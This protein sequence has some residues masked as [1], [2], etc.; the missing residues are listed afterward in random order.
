MAF[1]KLKKTLLIIYHDGR[2]GQNC[3]E[4]TLS[5]LGPKSVIKSKCSKCNKTVTRALLFDV[6]CQSRRPVL[7]VPDRKQ[8]VS[9]SDVSSLIISALCQLPPPPPPNPT[10]HITYTNANT[11]T[12]MLMCPREVGSL[13]P[14]HLWVSPDGR[15]ASGNER[16]QPNL[17]ERIRTA[18]HHAA[19]LQGVEQSRARGS[20]ST[21]VQAAL[22]MHVCLCI[23]AVTQGVYMSVCIC[24]F[25]SAGC[26]RPCVYISALI[27]VS[28]C[29]RKHID[30]E[31]VCVCVCV[32]Q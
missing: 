23:K 9:G 5:L 13:L 2:L 18:V 25:I 6:I 30:L 20:I 31:G 32:M 4:L 22:C 16:K 17:S 28:E 21:T 12:H 1:F 26:V 29:V 24:L 19:N 10:H 14:R 8:L 11:H 3:R 15:K 7:W 27:P